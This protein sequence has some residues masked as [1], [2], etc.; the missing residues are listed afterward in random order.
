[1]LDL[2]FVCEG[3]PNTDEQETI[4]NIDYHAG[5]ATVYSSKPQMIKKLQQWLQDY[6]GDTECLVWDKYGIEISVPLKWVKVRPPSRRTES[7]KE[8]ARE[9]LEE[10]RSRI[11]PPNDETKEV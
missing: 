7:W 4:I 2:N 1:M 8:A 11:N 5:R 9:R 3:V 10:A 6:R